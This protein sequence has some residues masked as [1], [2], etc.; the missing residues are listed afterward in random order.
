MEP[1]HQHE[2]LLRLAERIDRQGLNG[3][4]RLAL[5]LSAPLSIVGSHLCLFV[6]PLLP[7]R[8]RGYAC[9]FADEAN[10]GELRRLLER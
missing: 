4:A 9:L 8:W 5:D 3:T 2:L 1:T 7:G 6:Q 10:W